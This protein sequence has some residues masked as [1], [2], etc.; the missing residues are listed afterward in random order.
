MSDDLTLIATLVNV[1]L[2]IANATML[3]VNLFLVNQRTKESLQ[4]SRKE[5]RIRIFEKSGLLVE[6]L[7]NN[8]QEDIK[9]TNTGET[10]I[11]KLSLNVS[12][13]ESGANFLN[14]KYTS[15]SSVLKAQEFTIPLHKV[16]RKILAEKKI[17]SYR[18]DEIGSEFDPE[19]GEDVPVIAGKWIARKDF[20]LDITVKT[21]YEVMGEEKTQQDSFKVSY[22]VDPEFYDDPWLFIESD[23]FKMEIQKVSGEWQ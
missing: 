17:M 2:S 7:G 23:N 4:L 1:A 20:S 10:S 13:L 19:T 16:L 18:E 15:K 21:D 14:R 8:N 6:L 22:L 12:V 11:D 3:A 9:V 5:Q